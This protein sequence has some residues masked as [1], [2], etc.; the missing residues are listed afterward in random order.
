MLR[1]M[2]ARRPAFF[3]EIERVSAYGTNLETPKG[4]V[5]VET[6]GAGDCGGKTE[7][8]G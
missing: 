2:Y 8:G 5:V 7:L 6:A 4:R 3:D 1:H